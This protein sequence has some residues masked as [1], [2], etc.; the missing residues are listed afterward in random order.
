MDGTE[1]EPHAVAIRFDKTDSTMEAGI[2][3]MD[4]MCPEYGGCP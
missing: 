3:A 4:T 2:L 1:S